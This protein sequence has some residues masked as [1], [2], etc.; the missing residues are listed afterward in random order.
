MFS[1]INSGGG[2]NNGNSNVANTRNTNNT[3]NDHQQHRQQQQQQHQHQN[4]H[5]QRFNQNYY[6]P[7]YHQ[8]HQHHQP[9]IV[10][11]ISYVGTAS[12]S[13]AIGNGNYSGGDLS[14]L[15]SNGDNNGTT[16]AVTGSSSSSS[17]QRS[18][19]S[20][21]AYHNLANEMTPGANKNNPIQQLPPRQMR[22]YATAL[23]SANNKKSYASSTASSCSTSSSKSVSSNSSNA[24]NRQ[25]SNKS[26]TTQESNK[27]SSNLNLAIETLPTKSSGINSNSQRGGN[28]RGNHQYHHNQHGH[29]H[30][31]HYHHHG[32]G[33]V[34]HHHNQHT[35]INA[36]NMVQHQNYYNLTYV[37]TDGFAALSATTTRGCS[38][39]PQTT[40]TSQSTATTHSGHS[41]KVI[42]SNPAGPVAMLM[43]FNTNPVQYQRFANAQHLTV[44]HQPQVH[45][46]QQQPP[47]FFSKKLMAPLTLTMPSLASSPTPTG[48]TLPNQ[49]STVNLSPSLH[50][51][52]CCSQLDEATTAA[53]AAAATSLTVGNDYDSDNSSTH[54]CTQSKYMSLK[55]KSSSSSSSWTSLTPTTLSPNHICPHT[56]TT[57]S[58]STSTSFANPLDYGG[59]GIG[60][61]QTLSNI[62]AGQQ[63]AQQQSC[64]FKS[65]SGT[66]CQQLQQLYRNGTEGGNVITLLNLPAQSSNTLAD[67]DFHNQQHLYYGPATSDQFNAAATALT[68]HVNNGFDYWTPSL[69]SNPIMYHFSSTQ[70]PIMPPPKAT[71]S[72][73]SCCGSSPAPSPSA[74]CTIT[75]DVQQQQ[76]IRNNVASV[77]SSLSPSA[78]CVNEQL[79]PLII[80]NNNFANDGTDATAIAST[81]SCNSIPNSLPDSGCVHDTDDNSTGE[82]S[83]H[84]KE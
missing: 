50:N 47:T 78:V 30:H 2:G 12:S 66:A 32:G 51:I 40:A 45:Q 65:N 75:N 13:T 60:T 22:S 26:T 19:A 67:D 16:S 9:M 80:C 10:P 42:D 55:P 71:S 17:G 20:Y 61:Q 7:T 59:G 81:L 15:V 73:S 5:N 44:H 18:Y 3:N 36:Q 14:R 83:N 27:N 43:S 54:S 11:H 57:A 84:N 52:I 39:A 33:S 1:N 23:S 63:M 41:P 21:T 24:S 64:T 79:S 58:V 8:Q 72:T 70:V 34:G 6:V 77:S 74:E 56:H 68:N 38:P 29:H 4:N 31:H 48:I 46:Y 53:A 76:L 49:Q 35:I 37:S 69:H 25:L 82:G 28:Q 62:H